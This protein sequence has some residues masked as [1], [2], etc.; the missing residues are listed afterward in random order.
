MIVN[1]AWDWI[2]Y[3]TYKRYHVIKTGLNPGYSDVTGKLLP[4]NF[5]MLQ[6]FVEIEMANMYESLTEYPVVTGKNAGVAYL[7][8]EMGLDKDS[9]F[10]QAEDAREIYD[11][12]NWWT[13]VRPFRLDPWH[14]SNDDALAVLRNTYDLNDDIKSS[15][16]QDAYAEVDRLEELYDKEDE[17]MLIR[18][19]KIRGALWT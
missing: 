13:N 7:V 2:K 10:K 8:W 5:T 17:E 19:I 16:Y 12:Y 3:R 4:T 11:L 9:G 15:L 14:L 1:K 6:D 18:L